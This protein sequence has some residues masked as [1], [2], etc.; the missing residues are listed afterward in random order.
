[1]KNHPQIAAANYRALAAQEVV[2]ETRAGY[3][4]H[5][6]LYV[7]AVGANSEGTRITAGGLNNP[8]VY[9][10]AAGGVELSQYLTDFGH[11][12]NLTAGSKYQ[13]KAEDQNAYATKEQVLLEV[14]VSYFNAL[15]AQAVVR[16]A[17]QTLQT[18]Q[19]LLDQVSL[20]AS[21]KLRS[22]LDVSFARV[23]LQQGKLLLRQSQNDSDAALTS[24]A[25]ALG[26]REPVKYQL[27]EQK[28]EFDLS[29]N[30]IEQAVET[31]LTK[32][33][34]LLSLRDQREASLRYAKSERDA[35][36]PTIEAIGGRRCANPRQSFTGRL[37]GRRRSTKH[38]AFCRRILSG[39]S[40]RS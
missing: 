23:Q 29:T 2:K 16:V 6:G 8:T 37:C 5:A 36:L 14:N 27:L 9:D 30:D 39:A 20:L 17:Q 33:P 13:A 24:L 26:G 40:A 32:R 11:T 34:E 25:T 10:R 22:E 19:L 1:L 7:D 4:P 3:F 35:R 21:N 31:A 12:A 28:P 38:A 18:R 15:K